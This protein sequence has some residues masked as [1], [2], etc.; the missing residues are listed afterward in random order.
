MRRICS[1]VVRSAVV[2]A[3]CSH[4]RDGSR[5]DGFVF[6]GAVVGAPPL[7]KLSIAPMVGTPPLPKLS[8]APNGISVSGLSSG[9][10]FVVQF[11]VAFSSVVH[12]VGVFAG[13][14]YH[15]AVHRFSNEETVPMCWG[16]ADD[17]SKPGC[18]PKTPSPDVPYCQNCPS[19]RTLSYD[20][21]K[22]HPEL[23]NVS[24][25]LEYA[26]DQVCQHS[27]LS[28]VLLFS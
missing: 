15:C 24:A 25:L 27:D 8:I 28:H 5:S 6:I 7:P 21:C 20:H 11:Q 3:C 13:Q 18:T 1:W 16:T 2:N 22:R 14:P 9:A 12:G 23:V 10:D 17:G 26:K 4:R 19:G